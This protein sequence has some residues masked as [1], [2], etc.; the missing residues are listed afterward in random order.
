MVLLFETFCHQDCGV[1]G[2]NNDSQIDSVRLEVCSHR[3]DNIHKITNDKKLTF[4]KLSVRN[5]FQQ[6]QTHVPSKRLYSWKL[7]VGIFQQEIGST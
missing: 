5:L 1:S 2:T 3:A 4:R 7:I 6:A